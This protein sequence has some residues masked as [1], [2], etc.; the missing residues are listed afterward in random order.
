MPMNIIMT[1]LTKSNTVAKFKSKFGEFGKWFDMM[2][3]K[4][5]VGLT[6]MFTSMVITFKN[7]SSPYPTTINVSSIPG[8]MSLLKSVRQW[9]SL[10]KFAKFFFSGFR[11]MLADF[12][13]SKTFVATVFS[14]T[15][16]VFIN[17]KFFTTDLAK[18]AI[19]GL[20]RVFHKI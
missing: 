20:F 17:L 19:F 9:M 12:N 4:F 2:S 8:F 1:F 7:F 18:Y 14:K 6:T 3:I 15:N 13:F 16:P 5:R 10:P 11:K